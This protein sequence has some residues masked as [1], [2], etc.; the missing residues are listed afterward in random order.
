MTRRRWLALT[1]LAVTSA[2]ASKKGT[3]FRGYALISNAGDASLAV[4]DLT[5]FRLVRAIPLRAPAS[6]TVLGREG[7]TFALTPSTGSVHMIDSALRVVKSR[8]FSGNLS[9][10]CLSPDGTALIAIATGSPELI[11]A[12]PRALDVMARYK[13]SA[14]PSA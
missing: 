6:E 1:G 4:V 10:M 14:E 13:L 2:C 8:R 12:D 11:I 3:G 9:A 7:Q 5:E